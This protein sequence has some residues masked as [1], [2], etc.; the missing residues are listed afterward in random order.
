MLGLAHR[1]FE[2]NDYSCHLVRRLG[3]RG[4]RSAL[5]GQQHV[6]P[7][8]R[9]DEL[10]GYTHNLTLNPSQRRGLSMAEID[11]NSA[12]LAARFIAEQDANSSFYVECGFFYPHRPYPEVAEL[13][14]GT[15][16]SP[17]AYLPNTPDTRRD[18]A[19]YQA[20]VGLT[21][22]CFGTVLDALRQS[23]W[24][25]RSIIVVTTDHGPAFPWAKCNLNDQGTGVMMMVRFPGQ[26]RAVESESM[27]TH[28][29]IVPTIADVLGWDEEEKLEGCSLLP[30]LQKADA[31]LHRE[32]FSEVTYHA[33]Y[34]P[35]R[36]IRS[37]RFRY[38]RRFDAGWSRP[39][40]PNVD[41]GPSKTALLN[42]GLR[43]LNVE[44]EAFY[45]LIIDPSERRNLVGTPGYSPDL[46]EHCERLCDWME[47]TNDPLLDHPVPL[48]PGALTTPQAALSHVCE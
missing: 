30:I 23:G 11:Q 47:R 8:G 3:R 33:S 26:E 14:A 42:A 38:V 13:R 43:G 48:P 4:Y 27:V 46:N 44:S 9:E 34:E 20:A 7:F 29:D 39:V 24:F 12:R 19:G 16:V 5:F 17:P 32:I 40:L 41:D 35:M 25:D 36:S 31:K 6:A 28:L 10:I 37:E 1:G 45:D 22:H 2:M 15:T 21:D 18:M